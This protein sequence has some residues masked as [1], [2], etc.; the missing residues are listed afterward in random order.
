VVRLCESLQTDAVA[1]FYEPSHVEFAY[2]TCDVLNNV[3]T[4]PLQLQGRSP[5]RSITLQWR[6]CVAR[7]Y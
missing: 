3:L 6:L 5:P 2:I 1:E 7:G 4:K